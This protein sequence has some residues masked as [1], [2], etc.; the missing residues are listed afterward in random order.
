MRLNCNFISKCLGRAVEVM[1]VIPSPTYPDA[2]GVSGRKYDLAPHAK[3]PVLYLF[4]G[5]GNDCTSWLAYT[6]AELFAE[7]NNIALACVSAENKFYTDRQGEAW[8]QFLE[9]ELPALLCGYFPISARREDTYIAGLSMGGYGAMLHALS[10]PGR[11][12][13]CGVF[14]GAIEKVDLTQCIR[15]AEEYQ[16]SALLEKRV[17]EGASLPAF[18]VCCGENDFIYD[19]S[20]H[21]HD[22]MNT[23]NISHTWESVPGYTHEW[24]FWDM[25]LEKFIQWLPRTDD[26]RGN[27]RNV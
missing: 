12:A 19:N 10:A 22:I 17:R 13:A 18:Y 2:L 27:K 6:R 1:L 5:V 24:R 21:L 25:E 11:Y 7:E 16:I 14:S 23:L 20:V 3:Y 26:Y 8:E 9:E 4:H 15:P